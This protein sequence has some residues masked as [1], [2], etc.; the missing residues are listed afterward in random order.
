MVPKY[1]YRHRTP[2]LAVAAATV[3]TH[4]TG[5]LVVA[6]ALAVAL[7]ATIFASRVQAGDSENIRT[8]KALSNAYAEVVG[9]V[10]PAVVG[11]ETEKVIKRASQLSPRLYN[12]EDP[13]DFFER[14]FDIPRDSRRQRTPTPRSDESETMRHSSVGTGIVIDQDGHILTN[15]HVVADAD[16]IKVEFP[17]ENGKSY[18]AEV[19]GRDPNSDLAVIKLTEKPAVLPVATLG[20]SDALQPGNIIIAIGS[21]LGFKQS[22]STGVV[23]AK[24]RTLNELPFER[25]IQTDAAINRGNSGGPMVNLN[26]EVVGINTLISTSNGGSMGIGFAIPINQAKIVLRQL[27]EKGSVTRGWL[28][29]MMNQD[30]RDVSLE[31]GHDGSGV[32][33]AGIDPTGPAAKAGLQKMDVIVSFD[34]VDIKDNEHLRYLVADTAPDRDV[35]VVIIRNGERM[36]I[37]LTLQAQPDDLYTNTSRIRGGGGSEGGQEEVNSSL[38]ITVRN[39]DKAARE[40]YNISDQVTTGVVVTQVDENSEAREAGVRPGMILREMSREQVPDVTTFRRILKESAGKDKI[41]LH[42]QAGEVGRY[43]VLNLK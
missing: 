3:D 31:L 24:G 7:L 43:L 17:S 5:R 19:V 35:P 13:L 21:P 33:I 12:N 38:G 6:I 28:G 37:S 36:E 11:I 23:S 20:D 1:L 16:N 26:G 2:Q 34:G 25:F 42:L 15:N 27:I 4:R 14:F 8:A 40:K 22:V 41:L 30:D 39:I 9:M 10:S 29:I 32:V 18:K